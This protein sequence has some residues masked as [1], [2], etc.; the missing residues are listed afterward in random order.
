MNA[1][2]N[3]NNTDRPLAGV[4][5]L[6]TRP[7]DQ[8]TNL[9]KI[10]ED[11]GGKAIRFPAMEITPI[12]DPQSVTPIIDRLDSYDMAIFIS[13]NAVK[14]A[15]QSIKSKRDFPE[16]MALA[17]IGNATRKALEDE[18]LNVD[19]Y[20]AQQFDSEALLALPKMQQVKGKRILIFRGRGGR[21]L[22]KNTL[23]KRGAH[24]DY[25]E[26]YQRTMPIQKSN[27]LDQYWKRNAIDIVTVTS[28]QAL[29]NLFILAGKSGKENLV[30]TPI[31]VISQRMVQ[32]ALEK[33]IQ[34][35]IMVAVQANDDAILDTI[36]KWR[37]NNTGITT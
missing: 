20:P 14:Y 33:G 23:S 8:A 35:D 15:I 37:H 22:L 2:I 25:A 11:A 10:I 26:L 34:A 16:N 18:G 1:D 21:E 29:D 30:T 5:V 6:V 12:D 3:S 7:A 36:Q 9:C 24:V 17:A 19:I 13:A 32:N 31:V 27:A 28:N 4:G